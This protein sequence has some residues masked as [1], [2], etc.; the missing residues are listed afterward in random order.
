MRRA[1]TTYYRLQTTYY[2]LHTTYHLVL[3]THLISCA[4]GFATRRPTVS[5]ARRVLTGNIAQSLVDLTRVR[6]VACVRAGGGK[7]PLPDKAAHPSPFPAGGKRLPSQIRQPAPLLFRQVSKWLWRS[8][9]N[10][11]RHLHSRHAMPFAIQR[12]HQCHRG[13]LS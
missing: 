7:A 10:P 1:H 9:W 11:Q 6:I 13:E 12:L 8:E 3:T 2:I 5:R 4:L